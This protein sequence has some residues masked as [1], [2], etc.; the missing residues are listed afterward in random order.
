M[1]LDAAG[2]RAAAEAG[3]VGARLRLG[4]DCLGRAKF[5][6]AADWFRLASAQ[7]NTEAMNALATLHLN[8]L[9]TERSPQRA[10]E[11]LTRAADAGLRE[12]HYNLSSIF[13]NGFGASRD[14]ALAQ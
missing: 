11:L 12:A 13:Y 6:E 1:T 14:D 3:E 8:G 9:G 5:E 2:L 10:V 4:A 7:G